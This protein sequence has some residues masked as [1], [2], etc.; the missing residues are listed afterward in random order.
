MERR[1]IREVGRKGEVLF[2]KKSKGLRCSTEEIQ[3][4]QEERGSEM[5]RQQDGETARWCE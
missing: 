1:E 3:R 2:E 4:E 5:E